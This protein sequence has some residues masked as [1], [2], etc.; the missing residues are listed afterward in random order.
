MTRLL[1]TRSAEGNAAWAPHVRAAGATP[2]E[3]P[4]LH[5]EALPASDALR[6]ALRTATWLVVTSAR[7]VDAVAWLLEGAAVGLPVAVVGDATAAAARRHGWDVRLV[8][9]DRMAASLGTALRTR[10]TPVDYALVAVADRAGDALERALGEQAR[11]VEVY[12]TVP[13]APAPP[14]D[15]ATLG[16]AAALLASPSAVEGLTNQAT[17]PPD[18]P[19]VSIG[20]TTSAA[21]RRAGLAVSAE[22]AA[23]SIAGLLAAVA[24]TASSSTSSSPPL[25]PR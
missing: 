9:P 22:A 25:E 10:F 18:L 2:V 23:P 6:D 21:L 11:R 20:P 16:L 5:T 7:G 19:L 12:R 8:A 4:C 15:L 14:V 13:A 24:A 17:V 3:L 1:L